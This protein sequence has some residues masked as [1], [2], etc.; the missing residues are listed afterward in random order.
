VRT[1]AVHRAEG[2]RM[3]VWVAVPDTDEI[4]TT[5]TTLPHVL[6][7][8]A[9]TMDEQLQQMMIPLRD[10]SSTFAVL[11]VTYDGEP[12]HLATMMNLASQLSIGVTHLQ[13][14]EARERA[15]MMMRHFNDWIVQSSAD[16]DERSILE[17]SAH[18]LKQATQVGQ[19]A[20]LTLQDQQHDPLF[21]VQAAVPLQLLATQ[22]IDPDREVIHLLTQSEQSI[23][24]DTTLMQSL[25][26]P[27]NSLVASLDVPGVRIFPMIDS[28]S[29]LLG[30]CVLACQSYD[31]P[32]DMMAMAQTIVSQTTLNLQKTRLLQASQKQAAQMQRLTTFAEAMQASL[33]MPDLLAILLERLP[34]L[35]P[36]DYAAVLI[37]DRKAEAL[38][39]PGLLQQGNPSVSPPGMI[40]E[41]DSDTI[42][43]HVWTTQEAIWI[44]AL[45]ENWTWHHPYISSLQTIL[46]APLTSN[47]VRIGVLEIGS[48]RANRYSQMDM[49]AF[50][51]I[52]NQLAIGLS[53]AEAYFQSQQL[54]RNKMLANDIVG[55]LQRQMEVEDILRITATELG[56]ALGARRARIRLGMVPQQK[57]GE[58]DS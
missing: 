28:Q 33:H 37:Y 42:A 5:S 6:E 46:A 55:K 19:V 27:L 30:M 12:P 7:S 23:H 17:R 36:V 20:I 54:A 21:T 35:L 32:Q 2:S 45:Q 58:Q 52:S 29:E 44:N 9:P 13:I 53:N 16:R 10:Q 11:L 15:A 8:S 50:E 57:N 39:V 41:P 34:Y 38:R 47:G 4:P 14:L 18:I 1:A 31:M 24:I 3:M 43:E 26:Q 51:Q 48:E 40:L 25:P 22:F 49:V 56:Q